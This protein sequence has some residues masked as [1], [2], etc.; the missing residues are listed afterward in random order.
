MNNVQ[1]KA[2]DYASKLK[3]GHDHC[4]DLNEYHEMVNSKDNN[5]TLKIMK[6]YFENNSKEDEKNKIDEKLFS[7]MNPEIKKIIQ[8]FQ[9]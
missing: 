7:L 1:Q 3:L 2:I 6:K 4:Y 8:E 9:E 5:E